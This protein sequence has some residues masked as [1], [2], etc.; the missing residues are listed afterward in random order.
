MLV[1]TSSSRLARNTSDSKLASRSSSFTIEQMGAPMSSTLGIGP[2][3]YDAVAREL[4]PAL[5]TFAL[6]L[7]KYASTIPL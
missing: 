5:L 1:P 7:A 3:N 6:F 4:N 2:I